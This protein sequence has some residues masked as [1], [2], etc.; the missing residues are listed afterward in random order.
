MAEAL[1]SYLTLSISETLVILRTTN[2]R[3]YGRID[4]LR[5]S[6]VSLSSAVPYN[7]FGSSTDI[8]S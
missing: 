8:A 6:V 4:L 2:G 1:Y 5:V 3:P 7:T